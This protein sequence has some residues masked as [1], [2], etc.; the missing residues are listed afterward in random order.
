M[1]FSRTFGIIL[2]ILLLGAVAGY[3]ETGTP[4]ITTND[5]TA[6]NRQF[7]RVAWRNQHRR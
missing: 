6:V 4:S 1:N 5:A 2:S 3:S 7:R